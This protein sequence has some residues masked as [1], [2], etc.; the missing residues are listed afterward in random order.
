MGT[1][2]TYLIFK[3]YNAGKVP[4]WYAVQVSDTTMFNQCPNVCSKK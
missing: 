2:R 4:Q 3:K 1:F